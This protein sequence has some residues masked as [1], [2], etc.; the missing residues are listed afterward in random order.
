MLDAVHVRWGRRR[1]WLTSLLR[2]PTSTFTCTS[3]GIMRCAGA[4]VSKY[5]KECPKASKWP[6][7]NTTL[8]CN[9]Q[10]GLEAGQKPAVLF[11]LD[12][13]VLLCALDASGGPLHPFQ[14]KGAVSFMQKLHT[15]TSLL[16]QCKSVSHAAS[17][18]A[19]PYCIP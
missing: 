12:C 19:W 9:G 13:A 1:S 4:G 5:L 17:R 8:P 14:M 15:T 6:D 16:Y 7:P 2:P 10:N 3:R 18:H 11:V